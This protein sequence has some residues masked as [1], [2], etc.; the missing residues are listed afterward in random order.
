MDDGFVP[1]GKTAARVLTQTV[2][3]RQNPSLMSALLASLDSIDP[4]KAAAVRQAEAVKA[5]RA[6]R[7]SVTRLDTAAGAEATDGFLRNLL[8]GRCGPKTK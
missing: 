8:E 5:R 1:V 6:I 4:E 2:R 3:R 7:D